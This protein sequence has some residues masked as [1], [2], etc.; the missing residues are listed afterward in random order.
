M[1][2]RILHPV[3]ATIVLLLILG[4]SSQVLA[5]TQWTSLDGL[6]A[7]PA[8]QAIQLESNTA[9]DTIRLH[10]AIDG[11]FSERVHTDEGD[12]QKIDLAGG[13]GAGVVGSPRLPVVRRRVAIP[14]GGTVSLQAT[15]SKLQTVELSSA[16]FPAQP[17]QP[18]TD[19]PRSFVFD[20]GAYN[21]VVE[22]PGHA[23]IVDEQ[24]LRGVRHVLVEFAPVSYD[25][26]GGTITIAREMTLTVHVEEAD[27]VQTRAVLQRTLPGLRHEVQANLLGVD[28][29]LPQPKNGPQATPI[30]YVLVVADHNGQGFENVLSPLIDWKQEKGFQVSV[31]HTSETGSSK[32]QIK[33]ALRTLYESPAEGIGV[34]AYVIL[35]GDVQHIPFWEGRGDGEDQAADMYYG[36]MDAPDASYTQDQVPDFHVGRFSVAIADELEV[37]VSKTLAHE[38]PADT[39]ADWFVNSLWVA[40]DDHDALG[41]ETHQWVADGFIDGGMTLTNAFKDQIGESQAVNVSKGAIEAGMSIINYSG[42]G[43]HDGWACVPVDNDYVMDL[44]DTGAYPFVITNACQTGQFQYNNQG[45]CFSEAWLKS[46][47]GAVAS[48]AASNNSLW[49]EDDLIEKAVWSAFW[50]SL[51]SRTDDSHMSGYPWPVDDAYTTVGQVTDMGLLVFHERADQS[52]SVQ[53]A[54][55]EYNVMGDPSVDLWTTRPQTPDVTAPSSLLMGMPSYDATVSIAGEPQKNVLVALHKDDED[56]HRAAMTDEAGQVSVNLEGIASP[57]PLRAVVT[58]H[59]LLPSAQSI[60]IIPPGGAFVTALSKTWDDDNE[61]QSVGNGNLAASPGETLELFITAKNYGTESASNVMATLSSSDDCLTITQGSQSVGTLSSEQSLV[62]SNPFVVTILACENNHQAALTLSF[63]SGS[64]TWSSDLTLTIGNAINGTVETLSGGNAVP[65]TE[66]SYSGP[67]NGRVTANDNG[68]FIL[69]GLDAGEYTIT[70]SHPNYLVEQAT[71]TV[72]SSDNLLFTLGRPQTALDPQS[73]VKT[74]A[75]TE[76]TGQFEITLSNSGDKPLGYLARVS[77]SQGN[78]DFGYSFNDS[79]QGNITSTWIDLAQGNRTQLN[80]GD[81][82]HTNI[83][84]PFTFNYYGQDFTELNVASNG[85]ASF[86]SQTHDFPSSYDNTSYTLPSSEAPAGILAVY[87]RDMDPSSGGSI[88]WGTAGNQVVI[89]W[90]DVPEY[91]NYYKDGPVM[92]FQIVLDPSGD[93]Q[94]NYKTVNSQDGYVGLQSPDKQSGMLLAEPDDDYLHEDLSVAIGP[95]VSWLHVSPEEGE[96]AAE[97]EQT[98]TLSYDITGMSE[99]VHETTL[100]LASNDLNNPSLTVPMTITLTGDPEQDTDNDGD[101]DINDCEP[102]NPNIYHGQTEVCDGVDNNCDDSIDET[103]DALCEMSGCQTGSCQGEAGCVMEDADDWTSCDGNP[104]G[105]CVTGLCRPVY[106]LEEGATSDGYTDAEGWVYYGI[107]LPQKAGTATVSTSG[108]LGMGTLNL[109]ASLLSEI[110]QAPVTPENAQNQSATEDSDDE[111][112]TLQ[113]QGGEILLVLVSGA[114]PPE[115]GSAYYIRYT[116]TPEGAGDDDDDDNT[117]DDDDDDDDDDDNVTPVDGDGSSSNDGC[118]QTSNTTV[119][120]LFAAL[121]LLGLS[122]RRRVWVSK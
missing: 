52:W 83:T 94:F 113:A 22:I 64:D 76:P 10:L 54:M 6:P 81:D 11:Y 49:S 73:V 25:P 39:T 75:L 36:T 112:L 101:P 116:F 89:S 37:V 42:H 50:P 45:D 32:E 114:T 5:K 17:P 23:R 86:G 69:Q 2:K 58:G 120:S 111:S 105:R 118:Q 87:W 63:Q 121:M 14:Y 57:G 70:A 16:L 95:R 26:A 53:Y 82:E 24:I 72:P 55:E 108:N 61:G 12:F 91:D 110:S 106:T 18:K 93:I 47:G 79:D 35:V 62:V 31:L 41:R 103:G 99:G 34:P 28:R 29:L 96:L 88:Y 97:D 46:P 3:F 68:H 67:V 117:N 84:L 104:D 107:T 9:Q 80:L 77:Y 122:R 43:G 56:W 119:L 13:A 7:A 102:N 33:A 48:W 60:T 20:P 71:V 74:L 19:E 115:S 100:R 98:L 15:M 109:Y 8:R 30:H 90:D 27:L 38:W 92:N 66:I 44:T 21:A 65:Q 40:S 59:N 1:S 51:R 4:T 78:D 85:F